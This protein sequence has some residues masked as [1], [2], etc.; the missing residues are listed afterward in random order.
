MPIID[1]P[2]EELKT[3]M[4]SSPKMPDF[5]DFWDNALSEMKAI[6]PNITITEADF[7]VPFATCYH[8]TYTGTGNAR[9][10]AKL[11]KPK[12]IDKP[13]PGVIKFHGYTANSGDWSD[14]L[15]YAASGMVVA[16][17]DCRGQ[18][19]LSEDSVAVKGGT[20]YG[21]VIK[22]FESG[23]EDLYFKHVFLDAA[24]LAGIVMDMDEVDETKVYAVGGSQGGAL[25]LACAALEPRIAKAVPVYPFLSD[26]KRVWDMDLDKEAYDGLRHFFRWFD[27]LHKREEELFDVLSYIDVQNLAPRIRG[28]V[29]MFT[30]LMDEICPPSTQFAAYNKI[31]AKKDMV[32]FPDYGHEYIPRQKDME[33]EFLLK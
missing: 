7:K 14:L 26:F 3:Y 6:D 24:K 23:K 10:Y 1:K 11:V 27:P 25:T 31:T 15:H 2:L 19:G 28:E 29:Y 5:D 22:G 21:F 12:S 13:A 17:M 4:G 16:A 9:I 20:L 32:I 8:L 30:G 33:L 18:G